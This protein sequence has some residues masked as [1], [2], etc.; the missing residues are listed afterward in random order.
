MGFYVIIRGP[1][2]VGKST[3]S[4]ALAKAIGAK[5]V[6]IDRIVDKRWDGGSLSLYLAANEVAAEIGSRH[7]RAGRPVIFD[8]CF[9]WKTQ[10]ADLESRLR[11]PHAVFTLRAPLETCIRRDAAR[12]VVH[13]EEAART[14]YRRTTRFESG[15]PID[16]SRSV[17]ETVGKM[18]VLIPLP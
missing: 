13:G 3:A 12:R 11:F 15:V 17:Q 2:G 9:Y 4:A 14:V 8:G 7:L 10:L 5:V 6:S 18:R 1:L 16:A